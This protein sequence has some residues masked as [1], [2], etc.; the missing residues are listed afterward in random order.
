[1]MYLNSLLV[2][3]SVPNV[4]GISEVQR[5]GKK[6]LS[7]IFGEKNDQKPV[8]LSDRNNLF[9]VVLSLDAYEALLRREE[10]E[11]SELWLKAFEVG[12][13]FWRDPSN[14]VYEQLL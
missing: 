12:A 4:R 14:D 13:D 3:Y 6:A 10:D 8:F 7:P 1:M 11:E 2:T 5:Q 9:G